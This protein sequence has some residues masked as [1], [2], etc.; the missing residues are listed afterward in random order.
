MYFLPIKNVLADILYK[1][2]VVLVVNIN[3]KLIKQKNL[4]IKTEIREIS[5]M[6]E[7]Q[8]QESSKMLASLVLEG[9]HDKKGMDIRLLDLRHVS[10]A[11][12]DYFVICSGNTDTQVRALMQSI[13]EQVEKQRG[14]QPWM[15][16][17]MTN[18][19]WI[20][21]DYVDVVAHVFKKNKRDYFGI[22]E[23]WGDAK[24]TAF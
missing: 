16:E 22:E 18:G 6:T 15:K 2:F 11:V 21:L 8:K 10:N 1:Y 17:G 7:I 19:E 20:I 9:M 5:N 23:L 12:V 4:Q 3:F 13:E 24:V 14:E